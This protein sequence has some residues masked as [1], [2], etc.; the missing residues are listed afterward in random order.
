MSSPI[1]DF[2]RNPRILV[3]V[4]SSDRLKALEDEVER[5]TNEN[6]RLLALYSKECDICMRAVDLLRANGIKWR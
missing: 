3:A 6:R 5:L 4:E 1:E 2:F